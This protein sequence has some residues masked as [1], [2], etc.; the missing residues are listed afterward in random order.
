MHSI[1]RRFSERMPRLY[2]F[3]SLIS[4]I[5][6]GLLEKHF[7]ASGIPFIC[8]LVLTGLGVVGAL[9][10]A[11]GLNARRWLI[12][13]SIQDRLSWKNVCLDV[14]FG[15]FIYILASFLDWILRR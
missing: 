8:I 4:A 9:Y 10:I 5:I 13:R 2:G 3:L 1:I 14:S 12:A 15:L 11:F 7:I 6:L